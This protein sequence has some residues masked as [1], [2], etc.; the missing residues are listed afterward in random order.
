MASGGEVAY[1]N[2]LVSPPP[3]C[4]EETTVPL[5]HMINAKAPGSL[6]RVVF[7][8]M[9]VQLCKLCGPDRFK[10]RTVLISM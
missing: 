3:L 10:K 9:A 2:P 1:C 6:L 4:K 7:R 5:K 8:K